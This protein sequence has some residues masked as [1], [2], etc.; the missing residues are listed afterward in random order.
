MRFA[1]GEP[2][3]A[4]G[5]SMSTIQASILADVLSLRPEQKKELILLLRRQLLLEEY[6]KETASGPPGADAQET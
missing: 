3:F 2:Y 6:P 5:L 1:T 4:G